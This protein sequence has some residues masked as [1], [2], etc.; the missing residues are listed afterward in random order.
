MEKTGL[1]EEF[2][3]LKG[4]DP[5][6]SALWGSEQEALAGAIRS[7]NDDVVRHYEIINEHRKAAERYRQG[8]ST[9]STFLSKATMDRI[10]KEEAEKKKKN[11]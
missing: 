6:R 1:S 7:G 8:K 5:N 10:D 11:K 2:S 9:G 3:T 4:R